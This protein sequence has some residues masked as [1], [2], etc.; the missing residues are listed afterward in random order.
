MNHTKRNGTLRME[1]NTGVSAETPVLSIIMDFYKFLHLNTQSWDNGESCE[2][3][4]KS[5][6]P[7][8]S[9]SPFMR[10]GWRCVLRNLWI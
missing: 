4:I 10:E 7:L 2:H 8:E 1:I 5:V 3:V 9:K 6:K